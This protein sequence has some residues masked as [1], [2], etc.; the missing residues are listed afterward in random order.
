MFQATRAIAIVTASVAVLLPAQAQPN[1]WPTKSVRV[2]M[3]FAPGGAGDVLARMIGP[4]LAEE[5]GQTFVVDNRS[6]AGGSLGGELMVRS[7]PDGY[8]I[9]VGASSYSANAAY[10]KLSWDPING[11]QPV[12]QLT[13]GPFVLAAHPGVQANNIKEFVELARAKPGTI[14]FGSSGSGG[15]PHLAGEL[16]MQ[17]SKTRLIH[18]PYKG[19]IGRAHV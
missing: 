16:F 6:G 14:T 1:A 2:I 5:Y 11:V 4:K 12:T 7:A 17:M 9:M 10:Y 18:A 15:V 3:P 8:T 13:K 19:E